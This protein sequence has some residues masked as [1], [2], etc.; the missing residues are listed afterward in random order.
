[1]PLKPSR[2][3]A[4]ARLRCSE[5]DQREQQIADVRNRRVGQQPFGI[6][7]R[8]RRKV[9]PGHGGNG[10]DHNHRNVNRAQ[11]PQSIQQYAQQHRPCRRFHRHRHEARNAGGRAFVCVR[12]PLVKGNGGDLEH[13]SG[14]GRQ[15]RNHNH[16]IVRTLRRHCPPNDRQVRSPGKPVKQRKPVGKNARRK[17]AQ[18]QIL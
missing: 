14:H 12:S 7:L 16:R 4:R 13:Q 6:R 15:Q 10:D 3:P 1:M 11:R 9:G 8:E 2:K 18:Q 5:R 17:R